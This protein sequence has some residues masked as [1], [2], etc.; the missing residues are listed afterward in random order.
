[1]VTAFSRYIFPRWGSV[2]YSGSGVE[3]GTDSGEGS[4]AGVDSGAGVAVTAA[5]GAG[6]GVGWGRP[7]QA[8]R[9]SS[10][11]NAGRRAR[12]FFMRAPLSPYLL[13]F[14]TF[15]IYNPIQKS[16]LTNG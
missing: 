5:V 12:Y 4:G 16:Q 14:L 13:F 15:K 6:L 2:G 10:R 7:A 11:A 1:M 3:V 8:P 9:E